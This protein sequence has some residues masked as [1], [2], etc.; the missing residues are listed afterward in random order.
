MKERGRREG[1]EE[2]PEREEGETDGEKGGRQRY[3]RGRVGSSR[4]TRLVG[5]KAGVG[6]TWSSTDFFWKGTE[7]S[8]RDHGNR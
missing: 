8:I 2:G 6:S 5:G 3:Q 7:E 1:K 4:R